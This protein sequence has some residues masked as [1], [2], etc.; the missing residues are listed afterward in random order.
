MSVNPFA[1]VVLWQQTLVYAAPLI[2]AA[3]GELLIERSGIL[4]IGI[5]GMMLM[6]AAAGF[7]GAA[8]SGSVALGIGAA[9]AASGLMA[10]VLAYYSVDLRGSQ[11]TVGLGLFVLGVG[12][13]SLLY[14]VVFGVR[15]TPPRIATLSPV[16]IPGLAD[17]PVAG[18]ILFRHNVLVYAALLLVPAVHLV[19]FKTPLG[20]RLRAAGENPRAVDTLGL[21]VFALRRAATLAGGL[22]IGGA[23]A[24]LPIALTGTFNDNMTA[25]RGWLALMLVIFGRW[26]PAW[27]LAGAL[28]F[29]S[30]ES[31]QF[32]LAMATRL[33]PPQ[34]LLMLPYLLALAILVWIYRGAQAPAAL[35]LPYDREARG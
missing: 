26:R 29:A 2:L 18:A 21:D 13:S 27:A 31:F 24:Y 9:M 11:I 25:G 23:G 5:E 28:L 34:F 33:V 16:A 10:L 20:L 4:N 3:M 22:L 30:V 8:R 17:V 32:R 14:R 1:D 15:L 19:L 35:A 7:V 12:L 6:G